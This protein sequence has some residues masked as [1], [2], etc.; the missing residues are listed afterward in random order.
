MEFEVPFVNVEAVQ[1]SG[2]VFLSLWP[3]RRKDDGPG[4]LKRGLW[5]GDFDDLLPRKANLKGFKGLTTYREPSTSIRSV[6]ASTHPMLPG[7]IRVL[8]GSF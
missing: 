4:V 8:K 6:V 5:I 2:E 3:H 1:R 7:R